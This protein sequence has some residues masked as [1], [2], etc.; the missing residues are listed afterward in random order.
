MM[1]DG[2]LLLKGR[3]AGGPRGERWV[4]SLRKGPGE[5]RALRAAGLKRVVIGLETGRDTL[6]ALVRKPAS[7]EAALRT[8]GILKEAGIEVGVVVLLGLGGARY[9]DDHARDTVRVVTPA[10]PAIEAARD[11]DARAPDSRTAP[12]E[13]KSLGD[14][15]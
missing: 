10:H 8:V 9:F 13:V 4:F 12:E 14:S 15:T 5:L 7:A 11:R 3:R 1:L 6:L 2:R